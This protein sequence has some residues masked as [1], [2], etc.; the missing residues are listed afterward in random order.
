MSQK[1]SH[2]S[3]YTFSSTRTGSSLEI[4]PQNQL[5]FPFEINFIGGKIF[6][7]PGTVNSLVPKIGTVLITEKG[8]TQ[9]SLSY[10]SSNTLTYIYIK[11]G[12][13]T[14]TFAFPD[15]SKSKSGY[16]TIEIGATVPNDATSGCL[17]IAT[18]QNGIV[19]QM[20]SNSVYG[21]GLKYTNP[22]SNQYEFWRV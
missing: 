4:E 22:A 2:G 10:S 8:T 12:F 6:I 14:T 15:R 21:R 1:L 11:C 16:P 19:N 18:I 7:T 9:P 3:G 5:T 17:V 20:V 13:D